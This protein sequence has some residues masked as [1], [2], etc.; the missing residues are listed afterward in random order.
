MARGSSKVCGPGAELNLGGVQTT[1]SFHVE[2]HLK[3]LVR[4][5][6]R[7]QQRE[8]DRRRCVDDRPL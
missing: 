6:G 2:A 1:E 4:E 7:H 8:I 3:R 5:V